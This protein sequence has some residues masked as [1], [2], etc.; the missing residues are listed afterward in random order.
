MQINICFTKLLQ[1]FNNMS[2][3]ERLKQTKRINADFAENWSVIGYRYVYFDRGIRKF[4]WFNLLLAAT[5]FAAYLFYGT[6]EDFF[7]YETYV[8]QSV[9][10]LEDDV[11]FPTVTFCNLN[12]QNANSLKDGGVVD[13]VNEYKAL[14]S[15][16]TST[17]RT[18]ET[19]SLEQVTR[20]MKRNNLTTYKDVMNVLEMKYTDMAGSEVSMK[21]DEES[22]KFDQ[23]P[24]TKDEIQETVS[25]Q[26]SSCYQYNS[27]FSTKPP[28]NSS[29]VGLSTGL[30]MV[31]DL[32]TENSLVSS[33]GFSGMIV[34]LNYYGVPHF[35]QRHNEAVLVQPGTMNA[36]TIDLTRS[37][38]L[39][40]P[41]KTNCSETTFGLISGFPYSKAMCETDCILQKIYER[42]SCV[43]YEFAGYV[44]SMPMCNIEKMECYLKW[45]NKHKKV[46][47][48]CKDNCP[49]EC[50]M[51]KYSIQLSQATLGNNDIFSRFTSASGIL[52]TRAKE[53][54]VENLIGFKISFRSTDVRI[55]TVKPAATWTSLL[56]EIGGNLGLCMGLSLLTLFELVFYIYDYAQVLFGLR[57][58]TH[59]KSDIDMTS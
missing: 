6:I 26:H 32:G 9:D 36:I 33:Y 25:W 27:Y 53:I 49:R 16:V 24:C 14:Y 42:C 21:V 59:D 5:I 19:M 22:C 34:T 18:N 56:G 54:V 1:T 44:G 35:L 45:R 11:S 3:N 8:E 15:F 29:S 10:Y 50:V 39:P 37:I 23:V 55:L 7:N 28:K 58:K 43:G 20:W 30:N 41:Y 4:I 52:R 12:P 57:R 17:D 51:H 48:A 46:P 2:K 47:R 40:H 31:L 13:S 38:L